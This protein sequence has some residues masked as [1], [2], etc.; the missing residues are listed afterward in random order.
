[1]SQLNPFKLMVTAVFVV[2]PFMALAADIRLSADTYVSTGQ[3]TANYGGNTSMKV[4]G[5]ATALLRFDLESSLPGGLTPDK[6]GRANLKVFVHSVPTAGQIEVQ[7]LYGAWQ[8][9][10]VS[11]SSLPPLGGPGSGVTFGVAVEKQFITVDVTAQV[12]Q[13]LANPG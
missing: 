3:P 5:G 13:W 8:E 2:C 12:K 9:G 1:M 4:G 11:Y 10:T 7:P 6:L